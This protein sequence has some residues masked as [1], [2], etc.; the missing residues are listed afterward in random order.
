MQPWKI[1]KIWN[2]AT[3]FLLGG[4][5]SLTQ[6]DVESLRGK[7]VIAVN[8]AFKLGRNWI[9]VVWFSDCRWYTWNFAELMNF[10]G[11][12]MGCPPCKCEHLRLLKV[13]R[14]NLS[15]ISTNPEQVYWNAN[16]GASAINAAYLLGAKRI[17]LLGYDMKQTDGRDNW[18]QN[19]KFSPRP[20]I[21]NELFLPHFKKIAEDAQN[22]GLE[23][24]NATL[25][26][27]IQEFKKVNLKELL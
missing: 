16:S 11:L 17:V 23:I 1:H 12:I 4:G 13:K 9:P 24:L 8:D 5:P 20:N 21:Y 6:A 22:L 25:D 15:G 19:H 27:A 14:K 26:S 7:R 10:K 18:H 3:V 2:D